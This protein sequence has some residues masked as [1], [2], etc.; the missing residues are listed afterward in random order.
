MNITFLGSDK[1]S[2]FALKGLLR[3][4]PHIKTLKVYTSNTHKGANPV[5]LFARENGLEVYS[6]FGKCKETN[7]ESFR[8]LV[9]NSLDSNSKSVLVACSFGFMVPGFVIDSFESNCFVIHPSLLPKYRG[10]SP[11]SAAL[12]NNDA[13]SGVSIVEMSKHKY[14]A[15]AILMQEKLTIKPEWVYSDLY[16]AL[17]EMSDSVVE[18][19]ILDFDAY[20]KAKQIQPE[21][22]ASAK[23]LVHSDGHV[24]FAEMTAAEINNRYRAYKGSTLKT[25]YCELW[26]E[27]RR[28]FIT[29]CKP[30]QASLD[31][32][33]KS[34][35]PFSDELIPVGSIVSGFGPSKGNLLVKCAEGWLEV[36]GGYF[37]DKGNLNFLQTKQIL[38]KGKGSEI[39]K[40]LS[41]QAKTTSEP[42]ATLMT[43]IA[44]LKRFI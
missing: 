40:L 31:S 24:R 5:Q 28:F 43:E 9:I 22:A 37:E 7:R 2:N 18:K 33:I 17:G 13:E 20:K 16:D 21:N 27:K 12:L 14:D 8:S 35:E 34:K 3:V 32:I 4:K 44:N 6:P 36:S 26:P 11:I 30:H 10:S 15:G 38:I 25:I 29:S 42:D 41:L 39:L 1:F 19:F 23:K